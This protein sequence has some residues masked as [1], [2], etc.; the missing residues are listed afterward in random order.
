MEPVL[1]SR[2]NEE[3]REPMAVSFWDVLDRTRT[4]EKI[5]EKAFDLS[6]FKTVQRLIKE[7]SIKYDKAEPVPCDDRLADA[8]FAAACRFYQEIGTYCITTGRVIR[9]AEAE[10]REGI[11][12]APDHVRIGEGSEAVI[13][14]HREI[15]DA[16]A[17]I[18]GGGLQTGLYSNEEAMFKISNAAAGE[19]SI[20]AL[21]GGGL[22]SI[23]ET[24]TILAGAPSEIWSYRRSIEV[25][26]RAVA[27]SAR[28][29]LPILNNA[30]TSAATIAMA[31]RAMGLRPTD[32]FHSTGTS[33]MKVHYD[34][35]NRTAFALAYSS[36]LF[37]G[38]NS[39]IGGFSGTPEGA[40]IV[41]TAGAM[42]SLMVN[43]GNCL[44]PGSIPFR[45]KSRGLR[46]HIW[47]AALALQ[48]L[49]RNTRLIL[50]G[51]V[52]NHP[53][54]GPGTTQFMYEN[55]AGQIAGTVS[56]GHSL[57]GSRKFVIGSTP[58]YGSPLESKWLGEVTKSAAGMTR[59]RA[60]EIVLTLLSKY[61]DRL[62]N[63]PEGYVFEQL[64]DV[65]AM[66]PSAEY[67]RLYDGVQEEFVRFGFPFKS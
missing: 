36:C 56:G 17:P 12:A 30:P 15:E 31:D 5:E 67:R 66:K 38:H 55:A 2:K 28:P 16:T 40:A 53:A 18:V 35:L 21:W 62:M 41:S 64:Y 20:D 43:R 57:N 24:H 19:P 39:V 45:V 61:E 23:D 49:T 9:F 50:D 51:S 60:N 44:K 11:A 37:V 13:L 54:A 46:E 65:Q 25:L 4:G 7:Y 32:P 26:R 33:E 10:I 52:G 27:E 8:V 63:A 29:G 14:R 47:V 59:G 42:Q 48:A 3:K 58:N 22:S 1:I 6:I 34:D